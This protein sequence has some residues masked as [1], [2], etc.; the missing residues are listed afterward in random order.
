MSWQDPWIW[1]VAGVVLG[2]LE[3]VLPGFILLGFA[4]GSVL[5]GV[6]LWLGLL[7]GSLPLAVLVLAV[8]SVLVWFA[9][10]RL[11]GVRSGQTRIWHHDIN[12]N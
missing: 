2:G 8:S 7:G 5:V 9:L 1:I 3:M 10:R 4:A 12:E 11:L 6:L